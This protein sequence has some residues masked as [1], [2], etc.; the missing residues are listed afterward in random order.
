MNRARPSLSNDTLYL[1][2]CTLFL[3]YLTYCIEVWGNTYQTNINVLW[4]KQKRALRTV[5]KVGLRY[6]TNILFRDL[7]ILKLN[8]L[9]K[10]KTCIFMFNVYND[11]I[12]HN[13]TEYFPKRANRC[14]QS[15]SRYNFVQKFVRTT[16]KQMTL[17][18][19]G[20]KLWNGLTDDFKTCK[21]LNSFK[22]NLKSSLMSS[23]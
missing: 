1:L 17:S 4:L 18:I 12:P 13:L 2:Y 3:P 7:R 5:C 22:R 6:H 21:N 23:Y 10:F 20:V 15:K 9:I 14:H 8:D 16:T 11:S 19:T